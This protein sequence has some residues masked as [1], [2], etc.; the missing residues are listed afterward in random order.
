MFGFGVGRLM[1]FKNRYKHRCILC[2]CAVEISF[3]VLYVLSIFSPF[4]I[5]QSCN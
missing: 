1:L 2:I 4:S 3:L 5:V